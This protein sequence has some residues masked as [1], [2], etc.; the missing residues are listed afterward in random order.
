MQLI[1]IGVNLTN[2]SF[3]GKHQEILDR[4]YAAGV[5][6]LILTGT[7]I[8]GSEQALELCRTLDESGR[9]LFTTAGIHPP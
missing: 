9:R 8:E 6:Q 2:P 1:D 3:A 7:S 5:C 4:A